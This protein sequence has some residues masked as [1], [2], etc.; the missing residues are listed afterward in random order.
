MSWVGVEN[1]WCLCGGG[2]DIYFSI[3]F[4]LSSYSGYGPLLFYGFYFIFLPALFR[5]FI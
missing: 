5:G 4:F 3:F 1:R 2:M